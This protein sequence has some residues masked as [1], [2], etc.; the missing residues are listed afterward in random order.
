[1]KAENDDG[2]TDVPHGGA[3]PPG[4]TSEGVARRRS[5]PVDEL[6]SH[7]PEDFFDTLALEVERGVVGLEVLG[8]A[9]EGGRRSVRPTTRTRA[10]RWRKKR[11]SYPRSQTR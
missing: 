1:M 2:P 7:L 9:G 10:C 3:R 5:L 4:A 6:R 11:K 8:N